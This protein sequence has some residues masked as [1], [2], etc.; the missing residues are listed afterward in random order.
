MHVF[1]GVNLALFHVD[2][3]VPDAGIFLLFLILNSNH[4][5]AHQ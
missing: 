4:S 2:F 5:F 1:A 3:C